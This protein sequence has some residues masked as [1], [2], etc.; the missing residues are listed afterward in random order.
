MERVTPSVA[1]KNPVVLSSGAEADGETVQIARDV[2]VLLCVICGVQ[3]K[4]ACVHI[5]TVD[6]LEEAGD[7]TFERLGWDARSRVDVLVALFMAASLHTPSG[8]RPQGMDV[9]RVAALGAARLMRLLEGS[10]S[11]TL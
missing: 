3:L 8:E 4:D 2:A 7:R 9:H 5:M 1:R 11:P 10:R 6:I